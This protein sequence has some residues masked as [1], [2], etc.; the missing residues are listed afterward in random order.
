MPRLRRLWYT[1]LASQTVR[2]V[3][4]VARQRILHT[5]EIKQVGAHRTLVCS[6]SSKPQ[7]A[8]SGERV[9]KRC[10]CQNFYIYAFFTAGCFF[11]WNFIPFAIS[12]NEKKVIS[13]MSLLFA[14]LLLAAHWVPRRSWHLWRPQAAARRRSSQGNCANRSPA[15][16]VSTKQQLFIAFSISFIVLGVFVCYFFNHK[17]TVVLM[18]T[19]NYQSQLIKWLFFNKKCEL[20]LF[21]ILNFIYVYVKVF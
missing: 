19:R 11:M 21:L 2:Q 10:H 14:A 18:K 16:P 6:Y 1:N 20:F 17:N 13:Y 3:F 12:T 4:G 7:S 5:S 9:L 15:F 8:R